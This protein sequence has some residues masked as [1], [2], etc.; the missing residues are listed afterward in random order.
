MSVGPRNVAKAAT[1]M[2]GSNVPLILCENEPNCVNTAKTVVGHDHVYFAV[3]DVI[4]SN[5]APQNL[6]E[7]NPLSI[8]TED[9]ELFIL[10][11]NFLA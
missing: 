10:G 11:L 5:T 2:T 1:L 7:S 8:V 3:P 4:T 6:L 9:G